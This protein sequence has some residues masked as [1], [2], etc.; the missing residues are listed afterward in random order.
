M[1]RAEE[2]GSSSYFYAPVS[3]I[4]C[5]ALGV[6][7]PVADPVAHC[8]IRNTLHL[9]VLFNSQAVVVA[10][11]VLRGGSHVDTLHWP[12]RYLISSARCSCAM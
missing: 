5:R 1:Q 6:D 10:Q 3:F 4:A 2:L 8:A 12:A 9:G 11:S 7:L